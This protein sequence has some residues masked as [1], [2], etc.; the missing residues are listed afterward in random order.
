MLKLQEKNDFQYWNEIKIK[1]IDALSIIPEIDL[2]TPTESIGDEEDLNETP[3]ANIDE[4]TEKKAKENKKRNNL[5]PEQVQRKK[6]R[7]EY[8]PAKIIVRLRE[9]LYGDRLSI[10]NN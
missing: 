1:D 2:D 8:T 3:P 4:W 10:F 6:S 5:S 9:Y 7:N